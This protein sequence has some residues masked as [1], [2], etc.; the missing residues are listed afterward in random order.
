[1]TSAEKLAD[2]IARNFDGKPWHGS[3]LR[4]IV[5][6]VDATRA[7]ARPTAEIRSVAELLAHLV[8]WVEIVT[9]RLDG[10]NPEIT[11][12]R[13]FPSVD[14]VPW[15]ELVDRMNTAFAKLIET[16]GAKDDA[17]WDRNATGKTHTMRYMVEGLLHHVTYHA[18]QI[19]LQNRF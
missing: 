7:F 3:S 10:K 6:N 16:V 2:D 14:G 9:E 13:D 18:A 1:M 17:F 12:E 5:E 11:P 8:A 15:P 19:A 4:R